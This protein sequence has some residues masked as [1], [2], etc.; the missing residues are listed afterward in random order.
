MI[1]RKASLKK[2]RNFKNQIKLSFHDANPR[3][4]TPVCAEEEI[5]GIISHINHLITLGKFSPEDFIP[6]LQAELM[7]MIQL[8]EEYLQYR[9]KAVGRDQISKGTYINDYDALHKFTTFIGKEK[10]IRRIGRE[11]IE[12]FVEYLHSIKN[13]HDRHYKNGGIM[14]KIR[15]LKIAFSYAVQMDYIPKNPLLRFSLP[16]ENKIKETFRYLYEDEIK[17]FREYF[18]NKPPHQLDIFDFALNTGMRAGGILSAQFRWIRNVDDVQYLRIIE[19]RK[20]VRD[21]PL[22][23]KCMEIIERR[24]SWIENGK[25]ADILR[26][27]IAPNYW[28]LAAG[29][30]K[31]GFI[32]FEVSSVSGITHFFMRARRRLER[33]GKLQ[34]NDGIIF[35]STRHTF[36]TRSLEAGKSVGWVR[37]VMGHSDIIPPRSMRK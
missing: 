27:S 30:A 24:R 5:P 35:H 18:S 31:A 15:H 9:K 23:N 25:Y 28:R 17:T 12:K 26:K 3:Y 32:F 37:E 8:S 21:I 14:A 1:P 6:G 22:N 13:K 29:R 11:D 20:K 4:F 19:K 2:R 36:A 33:A 7:T 10:P 16:R 34:R